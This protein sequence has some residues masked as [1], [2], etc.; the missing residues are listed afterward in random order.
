MKQKFLNNLDKADLRKIATELGTAK[1]DK[2]NKDKLVLILSTHPYKLLV[3][4]LA[5]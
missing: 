1:A 2:M 3:S 4:A 5:A